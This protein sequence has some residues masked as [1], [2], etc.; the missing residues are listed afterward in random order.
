MEHLS[1]LEILKKYSKRDLSH[2]TDIL[3]AISGILNALE[4]HN[5]DFRHCWGLPIPSI[6]ISSMRDKPIIS[7]PLLVPLIFC[8]ALGWDHDAHLAGNVQRRAGFPSWSWCGWKGPIGSFQELEDDL[9]R[10]YRNTFTKI[11]AEDDSLNISLEKIDGTPLSWDDYAMLD[12][13][14]RQQKISRFLHITVHTTPVHIRAHQSD[15][16]GLKFVN[17]TASQMEVVTNYHDD[18][19]LPT[20]GYIVYL[21][22]RKLLVGLVDE[23]YER[24]TLFT[25]AEERRFRLRM[26]DMKKAVRT[27]RLG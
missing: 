15:R 4:A 7:R 1:I 9:T 3:F 10:V 12:P 21:P 23:V 16:R 22:E 26:K 6:P 11:L 20:E 14:T 24:I 13:L 19:K 17:K 5:S 25:N 27:I 8:L 18:S 2:E